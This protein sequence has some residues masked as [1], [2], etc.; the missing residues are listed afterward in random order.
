MRLGISYII[1]L[2]AVIRCASAD[3]DTTDA[4]DLKIPIKSLTTAY[5]NDVEL[6]YNPYKQTGKVLPSDFTDESIGTSDL[7]IVNG[8]ALTNVSL[9]RMSDQ[10]VRGWRQ[11]NSTIKHIPTSGGA[12][13]IFSLH[14]TPSGK[15]WHVDYTYKQN[16][17]QRAKVADAE[18]R[19]L[20]TNSGPVAI[21]KAPVI[22]TKQ[23]LEVSTF[24]GCIWWLVGK[25]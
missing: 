14:L 19:V 15:I 9:S 10:C 7:V 2:L 21:L 8:Q 18:V 17:T 25:M 24:L 1:L 20:P 11:A 5:T 4:P 6:T 12:K 13:D 16:M 23:A 3:P 22:N